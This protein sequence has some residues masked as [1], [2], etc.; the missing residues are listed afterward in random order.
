M[1]IALK[2]DPD[3]K[4]FDLALDGGDLATDEGLETA[5]VL[6]LFTDRRALPEDRLPDGTADRR[7]WW[8]DAYSERPHGSRLWLLYR[9]KELEE[10]LRRAQT[11][12]Q[13]ALA[14]LVEDAVAKAVQVEAIHLR[15][16]VLQLRIG[17][18]RGDGDVL[19]RQYDYV[20]QRAA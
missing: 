15:R 19:E 16:G 3:T 14:W 6:S 12:A 2:Y 18:E 20:W 4:I 5:V 8:A 11:Y 7:G 17:I 10:V 1:D 13:E 9:E